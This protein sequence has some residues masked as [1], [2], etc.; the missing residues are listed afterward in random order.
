MRWLSSLTPVTYLCTLLG[1]HC[2][3]AFSNR[4]GAIRSYQRIPV[5]GGKDARILID[6]EKTGNW[7]ALGTP[8]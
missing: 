4:N 7:F 5:T 2:V 3:A 1:I 8:R 6:S